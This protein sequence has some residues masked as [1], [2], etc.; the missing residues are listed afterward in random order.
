MLI[1]HDACQLGS[2]DLAEVCCRRPV[3]NR[4]YLVRSDQQLVDFDHCE[5][6][7]ERTNQW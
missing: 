5:G 3:W 6:Y 7:A 1:Q 4:G 2:R